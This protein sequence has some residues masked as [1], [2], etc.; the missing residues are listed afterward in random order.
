MN[1]PQPANFPQ[2]TGAQ[3]WPDYGKEKVFPEIPAV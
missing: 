1:H 3:R 2:A